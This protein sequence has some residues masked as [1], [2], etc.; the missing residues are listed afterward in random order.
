MECLQKVSAN[1]A[2]STRAGFSRLSIQLVMDILK[3]LVFLATFS[4][5]H[6]IAPKSDIRE[7]EAREGN[8]K[9]LHAM[10]RTGPDYL[11]GIRFSASSRPW[12]LRGLSPYAAIGVAGTASA[13]EYRRVGVRDTK[14]VLNSDRSH[15]ICLN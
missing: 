1:G 10:R 4:S 5:R 13:E 14:L 8:S 11:F 9:R 15:S 12:R 3:N 6:P 2:C 7:G